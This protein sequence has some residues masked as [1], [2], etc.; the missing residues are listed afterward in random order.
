MHIFTQNV[1]IFEDKNFMNHLKFS[2]KLYHLPTFIVWHNMNVKKVWGIT[3]L[4]Y[5][6]LPEIYRKWLIRIHDLL[7]NELGEVF[8]PIVEHLIIASPNSANKE[9]ERNLRI[10]K[11]WKLQTHVALTVHTFR[12]F[13]AHLATKNPLL[14]CKIF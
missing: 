11:S 10:K 2:K 8:L 12:P 5:L 4:P 6:N 14:R 1:P 7:V 9:T 3:Y 13:P